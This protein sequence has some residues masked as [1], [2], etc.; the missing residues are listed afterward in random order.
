MSPEIIALLGLAGTGLYFG[1]KEKVNS[2]FDKCIVDKILAPVEG[3]FNTFYSNQGLIIDYVKEDSVIINTPFKELYGIKIE[4]DN[5]VANFI[6]D[7]EIEKIYRT[8][9][10]DNKA[11]F[12]YV[13]HKKGFYHRQ[14]LFSYNKELLEEIGDIY[15]SKLL[16][17]NEL[18]NAILDL[19]LQNSYSIENKK[20]N[21]TIDIDFKN[22]GMESSFRT[23]NKVAKENIYTNLNKTDLYQAYKSL[24]IKESDIQK[25]F[26]LN[27]NGAIWTYFD[28]YERTVKNHLDLLISSARTDGKSKYFIDLKDSYVNGN[29]NLCLTNSTAHLTKYSKKIIGTLSNCV[30]NDFIRKDMNRIETLRKTPFKYRDLEF[31]YLTPLDHL[32]NYVASVHKREVKNPDIW[33]YDKNKG[34]IHFSFSE[35][36]DSPHFMLIGTIGTGKSF[37]KQKI[38]SQIINLDYEKCIAHYNNAEVRSYDIGFSDEQFVKYLATNPKNDVVI[39]S[40]KYSDFSYNVCNIEFLDKDTKEE[41]LTFQSDLISLILISKGGEAL[42]I[43]ET[44]LFKSVLE[45]IYETEDFKDYRVSDV[46][47]LVLRNRLVSEGY[48]LN[49][50]LLDIQ[51]SKYDFL[52]KPL[53]RDV[54]N[55]CSIQSQNMQIKEEEREDYKSLSLKLQD[56]NK[57]KIFSKFDEEDLREVKFLSM[58]LNDFKESDLFVPIFVAIFQKRYLRDRERAINFKRARKQAP[59]LFYLVEEVKNYF[60][61]PYFVTMFEK[62]VLEARKYNVHFGLIGQN[63]E[64]IPYELGKNI[65]TKIF[66]LK[67]DKKQE[68]IKDIIKLYSPDDLVVQQLNKTDRFEMCVW[69][70]KGAFNMKFEVSDKEFDLF[71]TNTNLIKEKAEV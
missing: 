63:P 47:N 15:G 9:K 11:F 53:L 59:K 56:V 71:N 27:F 45:K 36:N 7:V 62:I 48:E 42:N 60:R 3:V 24:E 66:L 41:D 5:N 23:F 68:V 54:I 51:D 52:K 6:P 49:S 40:S 2:Q 57:L 35:E 50:R 38:I 14:Y 33:G 19:Y 39:L 22:D 31:D 4:G 44:T 25:L 17:G 16:D 20:I 46:E 65:D 30:K 61:V 28:M 12:W 69:Y 26:N 67:K 32:K 37:Q 70:S 55:F 10:Q 18:A 29:I 58:D 34:F 13:I 8:Y 1:N 64:H 21:K 43:A